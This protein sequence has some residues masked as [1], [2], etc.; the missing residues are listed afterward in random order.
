MLERQY[1][2]ANHIPGLAGISNIPLGIHTDKEPFYH[3]LSPEPNFILHIN[4]EYF[5]RS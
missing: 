3:H 4:T 1:C 5:L 2:K